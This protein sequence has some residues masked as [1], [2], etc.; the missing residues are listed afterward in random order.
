[1]FCAMAE[2]RVSIIGFV[3]GV[4]IFFAEI[5]EMTKSSRFFP[6]FFLGFSF[7]FFFS[8]FFSVIT[9]RTTEIS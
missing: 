1:M 3:F 7:F 6:G 4:H 5:I 2:S 9:Y 8:F